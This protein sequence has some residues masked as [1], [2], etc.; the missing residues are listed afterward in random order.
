[1]LLLFVG[2]ELDYETYVVLLLKLFLFLGFDIDDERF[3]KLVSCLIVD[4]VSEY[5]VEVS[6]NLLFFEYDVNDD[7]S[8]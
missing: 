3:W 7:N 1:M 2:D 8:F 4:R 5:F 6:E